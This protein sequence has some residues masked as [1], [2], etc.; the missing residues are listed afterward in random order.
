M[1][2]AVGR[3]CQLRAGIHVVAGTAI[4]PVTSALIFASDTFFSVTRQSVPLEAKDKLR[5]AEDEGYIR[6]F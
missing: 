3:S 1:R 4:A 5:F 2:D 6:I